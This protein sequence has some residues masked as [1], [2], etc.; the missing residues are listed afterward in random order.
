MQQRYK[1]YIS[2]EKETWRDKFTWKGLYGDTPKYS[3]TIVEFA[4][5]TGAF[6]NIVR[7]KNAKAFRKS[8]EGVAEEYT[9]WVLSKG[10]YSQDELSD[11]RDFFM[12]AMGEYFFMG[13]LAKVKC[14]LVKNETNGRIVRYDLDYVAPRL[15][16]EM[17]FGVDLTGRIS[18]GKKSYNCAIQVKFWNPSTNCKITEKIAS[19][20]FTDGVI[21]NFIKPKEE[22]NIVICWLGDTSKVSRYLR[23]NEA[24]YKHIV[25]IDNDVI[26]R[27]VNG[28]M[29]DFWDWM[30]DN[31]KDIKNL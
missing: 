26:D 17:D 22:S 1:D 4:N 30:Y 8:M 9:R 6:D 15:I 31:I 10:I 12:G 2:Q 23:Q 25:F 29:C 18:K 5:E 24:L 20:A 27:S 13:M 21:N 16:G 28:A 3:I 14:F 19:S 7:Y 11:I